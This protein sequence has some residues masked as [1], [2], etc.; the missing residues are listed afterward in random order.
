MRTSETGEVNWIAEV[1]LLVN[2]ADSL[3]IP[4]ATQIEASTIIA[5]LAHSRRRTTPTA[6]EK[7][8]AAIAIEK[9]SIALGPPVSVVRYPGAAKQSNAT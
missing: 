9:N 3:T 5:L 8:E 1:F 7:P 4:A 6:V 2:K